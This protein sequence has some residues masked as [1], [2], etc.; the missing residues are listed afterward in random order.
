MDPAR[1]EEPKEQGLCEPNREG[2]ERDP[3][4]RLHTGDGR[5]RSG[6]ARGRKRA[7][8]AQRKRM[9]SD[10]NKRCRRRTEG[11]R[12]KPDHVETTQQVEQGDAERSMLWPKI[13]RSVVRGE[14]RPRP[15]GVGVVAGELVMLRGLD[16]HTD[17]RKNVPST[18][19][20][21]ASVGYAAP[22]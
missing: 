2:R 5:T 6:Q 11:A 8:R 18:R 15:L 20:V 10:R 7:G 12:I 14:C 1:R 9:K 13:D 17:G 16:V 19:V 4:S 22:V 3:A 21:R